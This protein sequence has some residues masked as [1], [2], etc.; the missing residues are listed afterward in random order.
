[1]GNGAEIPLA[2]S[3]DDTRLKLHGKVAGKGERVK[4]GGI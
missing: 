3:L 1:M 2:L 4:P